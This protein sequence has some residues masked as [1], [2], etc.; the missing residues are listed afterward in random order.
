[1][2]I[3]AMLTCLTALICVGCDAIEDWTTK[4]VIGDGDEG[5]ETGGELGTESGEILPDT[6][7]DEEMWTDMGTGSGED[8]P[9]TETDEDMWTDMST[10]TG[11]EFPEW[12]T[13]SIP[14][15]GIDECG[16]TIYAGLSTLT[17]FGGTD[18]D[19]CASNEQAMEC[20]MLDA[21]EDEITCTPENLDNCAPGQ[22]CSEYGFCTCRDS[23]D[24]NSG[25]C[26]SEWVCVPSTCNG[27][28]KCSC[29]GGCE[30]WDGNNPTNTPSAVAASVGLEC[31]ES[32]VFDEVRLVSDC[33]Y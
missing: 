19:C 31:C 7:T 15:M 12:E 24:C 16:V 9:D 17:L 13:D 18:R 26:T 30:W 25:V 2:K 33:G 4:D 29:S 5:E 22:T 6:E 14:H 8:H 10:D 11:A 32:G 23:C 28:H 21:E 20:W 27:Y 1:M 3:M